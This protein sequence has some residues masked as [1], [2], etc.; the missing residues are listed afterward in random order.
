MRD[1]TV[2]SGNRD[3]SILTTTQKLENSDAIAVNAN[4]Y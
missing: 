1:G 3:L 2:K 4:D